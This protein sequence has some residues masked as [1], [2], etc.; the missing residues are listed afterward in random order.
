MDIAEL[1]KARSQTALSFLT[2]VFS[3]P[4][5]LVQID[6]GRVSPYILPWVKHLAHHVLIM[7]V[8]LP[9]SCPEPLDWGF[10]LPLCQAPLS[11]LVMK[12]LE[13]VLASC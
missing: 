7:C 1:F 10:A 9:M 8:D 6:G 4:W 5:R 2:W 13:H 3:M 12:A 11:I